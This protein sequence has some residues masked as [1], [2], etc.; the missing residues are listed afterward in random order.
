MSYS[1]SYSSSTGSGT[2]TGVTVGTSTGDESSSS[3]ITVDTTIQTSTPD[4]SD[5]LAAAV[6]GSAAALGEDTLA[7]GSISAELIDGGAVTS[8]DLSAT[9][10]AASEA[11][12]GET[13]DAWTDTFAGVSD[14]AEVVFGYT[15][16][17][18]SS[19]QNATGSTATST[20]TTN[21]TAYD[22]H[23][24]TGGNA[25]AGGNPSGTN[26]Q[27]ESSSPPIDVEGDGGLDGNF[28]GI[29]FYA[30]AV[31]DDSLVEGEFYA[32]VVEDELST[33]E[34]FVVL[35]VD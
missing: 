25:V 11:P 20:S 35:A 30:L 17:T 34:G 31:G 12:D 15:V 28:A 9:M 19:E 1:S 33:S 3:S 18:Q 6:G 2:S 8:A 10:V 26:D 24:D 27:P 16:N 14:G 29:E 7:T 13:T 4:D 23:P 22:I 5:G 21:V 32:L